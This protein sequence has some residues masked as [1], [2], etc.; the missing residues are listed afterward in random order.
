[1]ASV[2]ATS[3]M[4]V[5]EFIKKTYGTH[6]TKEDVEEIQKMTILAQNYNNYLM[7]NFRYTD[8]QYEEFYE[9]DKNKYR[10]ADFLAYSFP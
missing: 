7:D 1:M 10:Q 3:S 4:T 8:A 5:D 2:A 9:N 6:V